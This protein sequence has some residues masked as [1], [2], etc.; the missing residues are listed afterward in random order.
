MPADLTKLSCVSQ[1]TESKNKWWFYFS[2]DDITTKD[3]FSWDSGLSDGDK[4]TKINV[5][6]L[7]N[8][9]TVRQE[10]NYVVSTGEHGSLV[11]VAMDTDTTVERLMGMCSIL[12]TGV[13]LANVIG[14]TTVIMLDELSAMDIDGRPSYKLPGATVYGPNGAQGIIDTVDEENESVTVKTTVLTRATAAYTDI[15]MR[16]DYCSQ[17][18]VVKAPNG[19]PTVGPNN[20]VNL[21]AGL[22]LECPGTV[23][24]P[25]AP[26]IT[27]ASAQTITLEST[28]DCYVIYASGEIKECNQICFT[29]NEPAQSSAQCGV[30]FNGVEWKIRTNDTGNVFRA[31]RCHPLAKCI[32]TNGVLTRLSFV[33]WYD[34]D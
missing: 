31:T 14:N 22:V 24:N 30:W 9:T 12:S 17:Y 21:P 10:T 6:T 1:S 26:Q 2:K 13:E 3:Y 23:D 11:L 28:T 8:L 20:T 34:L 7:P 25:A 16:G 15:G 27:L 4:V 33:G 19:K 29:P 5:L 32:F 18:A